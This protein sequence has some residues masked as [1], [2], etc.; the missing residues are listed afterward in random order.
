MRIL[1]L[2]IKINQYRPH[3]SES[4]EYQK[5]EPW[6]KSNRFSKKYS[7]KST[8]F[9]IESLMEGIK[10][11]NTVEK[12]FKYREVSKI[13][14]H[15]WLISDYQKSESSA[16][17]KFLFRSNCSAEIEF[18]IGSLKEKIK[19]VAIETFEFEKRD[20]SMLLAFFG[21]FGLSKFPPTEPKW[22][23]I[24]EVLLNNMFCVFN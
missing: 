9:L 1:S 12:E 19:P 5:S 2:K 22:W 14:A 10:L 17:K 4:S 24:L 7:C 23:F 20:E 3:A 11:T 16:E 13:I 8:R 15:V 21:T 18:L 6:N